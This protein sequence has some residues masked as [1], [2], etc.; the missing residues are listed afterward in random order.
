MS[1]RQ[2]PA[3]PLGLTAAVV[4]ATRDRHPD[5]ARCVA[6][7]HRQSQLALVEIVVVDDGSVPAVDSEELQGA[8]P[9]R[10]LRTSGVGPATARNAGTCA[11]TAD[12]VLF[13]D[14]DTV[15]VEGWVSAALTRL[16]EHPE[17]VGVE[18]PV[19]SPAYD[20]LYAYSVHTDAP[21]H[22]WTCNI[23]YRR[24]VL[25][26]LGGFAEDAFPYAHCEDLDLAYRAL[27]VGPIG[28]ETEMSIVH[29]PREAGIM[30]LIR[31]G[32]W[33]AS[34]LELARRHPGHLPPSRLPI[35]LPLP[36]AVSFGHA[37]NWHRRWS[38]ER[39]RLLRDPARLAR[40]VT[41]A[42]G[43]TSV[44]CV[45]ALVHALRGGSRRRLDPRP[46]EAR[47]ARADT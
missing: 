36:V 10:L 11:V 21:G 47:I 46:I 40:F 7:I 42:V 19:A 24:A 5:L 3:K 6:T 26:G 23:A 39:G 28:F 22:H 34:E 2:S 43:H 44:A 18:G 16:H 14:D 17:E 20:P 8:V 13:T 41:I 45:T 33:S 25:E 29:T 1:D 30:D 32:R 27:A 31:R 15:P 37:R 38:G 35:A 4:I 12:V 9:L